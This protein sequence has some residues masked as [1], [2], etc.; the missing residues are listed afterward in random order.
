MKKDLWFRKHN[1]PDRFYRNIETGEE[2]YIHYGMALY[3]DKDKQ[4]QFEKEHF[5]VCDV[6]YPERIKK[7]YDEYKDNSLCRKCYK[8]YKSIDRCVA[9]NKLFLFIRH[10]EIIKK[11]NAWQR[12]EKGYEKY[13]PNIK[14]TKEV[15]F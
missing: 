1:C 15:S 13:N 5:V 7:Y 14:T 11:E 10:F 2:V 9:N 12:G 8:E 6:C 4:N 3:M